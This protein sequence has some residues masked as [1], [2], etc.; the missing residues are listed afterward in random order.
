MV[1]CFGRAKDGQIIRTD[2]DNELEGSSFLFPSCLVDD[3]FA[4][5]QWFSRD[6]IISVTGSPSGSTYS[7]A[8][9]KSLEAKTTADQES[10]NALAPSERTEGEVEVGNVGLTRVPPVTAIAGNL[11]RLW[12]SGGLE[13]VS[14]L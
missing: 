11:I 10:A 4:D 5:A 2:L 8:E 7:K 13:L 1:G 12:A 14:K 6:H 9:L 3:A